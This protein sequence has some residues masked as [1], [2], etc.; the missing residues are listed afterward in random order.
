MRAVLEPCIKLMQALWNSKGPLDYDGPH[1]KGKQMELEVP[2]VQKPHPP[3]AIAAGK[4]VESAEFAGRYGMYLLTGDFTPEERLRKF[5]DAM[6][7]AQVAAG[8]PAN[9]KDYRTT[10]VIYVAETDKQARADMRDCY[11]DIIAWEIANTP[12]HQ[13]ERIPE[14]EPLPTSTSTIW[15]TPTTCLSA[16]LTPWPKWSRDSTT[17]P[18]RRFRHYPVPRRPALRDPGETRALD[19]TVHAGSRAETAASRSR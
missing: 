10:R 12:H 9:R 1:W 14:A 13:V 15:L 8:R 5:G 7:K 18:G 11:N 16:A 2:P 6:V 17:R 4:T 3:L 19:G